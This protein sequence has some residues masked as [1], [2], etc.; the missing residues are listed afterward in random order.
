MAGERGLAAYPNGATWLSIRMCELDAAIAPRIY[1]DI[2]PYGSGPTSAGVQQPTIEQPAETK[3]T[4]MSWEDAAE[5]LERLREQGEPFTSQS[6]LANRFGCSPS[7]VHKA[8]HSSLTLT[9]WSKSN[10]A[11]PK[12]LKSN[13][14]AFS[15]T[16]QNRELKPDQEALIREY[17]Q[18]DLPPKEAPLLRASPLRHQFEYVYGLEDPDESPRILVANRSRSRTFAVR[19]ARLF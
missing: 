4:G 6:D 9:A 2:Q 10:A 18:R 15:C 14:V 19:F 7:T 16:A 1:G 13:A 12:G 17:L 11:I 5:R 8:I 3:P